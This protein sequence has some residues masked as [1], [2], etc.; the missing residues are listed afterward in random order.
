MLGLFKHFRHQKLASLRN[1]PLEMHNFRIFL[2]KRYLKT[3]FNVIGQ[4]KFGYLN[5]R[6]FRTLLTLLD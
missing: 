1:F 3:E 5:P 2:D 4:T 6:F